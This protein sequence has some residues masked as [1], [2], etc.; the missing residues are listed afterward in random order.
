MAL[1]ASDESETN[2]SV[3]IKVFFS[4]G[5]NVNVLNVFAICNNDLLNQL[6]TWLSRIL[7]TVIGLNKT[8]S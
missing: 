8:A 3:V 6:I 2:F 7:Y 1:Q 4:K 5:L